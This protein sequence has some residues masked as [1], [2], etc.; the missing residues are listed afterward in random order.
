MGTQNDTVAQDAIGLS[1]LFINILGVGVF[2]GLNGGL[3][4]LASQSIGSKDFSMCGIY[5]Q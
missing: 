2:F 4:T 5:L 3:E 1:N